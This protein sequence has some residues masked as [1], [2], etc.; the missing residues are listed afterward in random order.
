MASP[1]TIAAMENKGVK[2][3]HDSGLRD[4]AKRRVVKV[5][6]AVDVN[7]LTNEQQYRK[8]LAR[9][10]NSVTPENEM[11]WEAI[12]PTRGQLNFTASD[13]LVNFARRHGQV[14]RGH[15]LVWHNQL[16]Q[17][18]TGGNFTNEELEQILH[19]HIIDVMK[20]FKGRVQAWD[21]VNEPFNE[22]GTLRD[23]IWLR[24]MGPDYIAKSLQWAHEAD[25]HAKLY[26]NDYNIEGTGPKSDAMYKLVKDLKERGVPI[27]G[28]GFQSHL[29]IQYGFPENMQQNLQR[30]TDLGLK[31]SL[32]EVDV[33][34]PLPVT[35][36]KLAEQKD[37]FGRLMDTC[38]RVKGCE[39]FTVWGFTDAHSWVP[40]WFTGQGAATPFDES[41]RPK[42]AYFALR[43]EL[44]KRAGRPSSEFW[45][46]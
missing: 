17:W 46:K 33:R 12:E 45:D 14:V 37:Y 11:K 26:I 22:D 31:V 28:V 40:G 1:T 42:P 3:K 41:Y 9:E 38:L 29:G 19:K 39:S 13:Q 7:V 43:D 18:L 24:A 20:H 15:T 30:F 10:F 25:P 16:P 44:T 35:D 27:D 8:V 2:G 36:E 4:Y 23:S 21:V 34:M 6:T 5:G 32:T